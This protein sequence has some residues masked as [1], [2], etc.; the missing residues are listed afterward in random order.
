MYQTFQL[1][2]SSPRSLLIRSIVGFLDC[3][4]SSPGHPAHKQ[5]CDHKFQ[6]D[7]S[8]NFH[9]Y[10]PPPPSTCS[11]CHSN[12]VVFKANK[13]LKVLIFLHTQKPA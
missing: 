9:N 8:N 11:S 3:F 5:I 12:Q 1:N 13:R 10:P 4:P 7:S 6:M 2:F